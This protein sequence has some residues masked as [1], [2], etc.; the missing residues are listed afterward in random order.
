MV[1]A[2]CLGIS[3]CV[4][5]DSARL[6]TVNPCRIADTRQPRSSTNDWRQISAN[7]R[8]IHVRSE[9]G[10]PANT[11]S[12][13]L[14][15]VAIGG[16][17]A[18][19]FTA[20]PSGSARPGASVVNYQAGEVRAGSTLIQLSSGGYLDVYSSRTDAALDHRHHGW[21]RPFGKFERRPL[22]RRHAPPD[23]G[24]TADQSG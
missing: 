1:V 9:C 14:T 6:V 23:R 20:Y 16:G 22:H 12:A 4:V 19:F 7:V 18:G 11:T 5:Y 2:V 10:L 24:Q 17:G 15:L 3:A 13:S 8:R 21:V